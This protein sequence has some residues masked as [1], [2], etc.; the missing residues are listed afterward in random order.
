LVMSQ[1]CPRIRIM[2]DAPVTKSTSA[3]PPASSLAASSRFKTFAVT[4]GIA[5]PVLYLICVS[6]NLPLFTYHPAVNRVDFLWSPPR[7]GEGPA[8]YWYGWTLSVLV[9]GTIVSFLVTML[10]DHVARRI[11]LYLVWVLPML[12]VVLLAY[13]LREFWR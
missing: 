5:S 12:G 2:T 9:G 4:F 13:S 10:P 8:M 11:P 1:W 7:I 6:L 3:A